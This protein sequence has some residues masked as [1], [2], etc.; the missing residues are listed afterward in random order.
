[1]S[2]FTKSP[3]LATHRQRR[4]QSKDAISSHLNSY[5]SQNIN[6]EMERIESQFVEFSK[7]IFKIV[8]KK[9]ERNTFEWNHNTIQEDKIQF[10]T[11]T[12]ITYQ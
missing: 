10:D 11:N 8:F 2:E 4:P 12:H 5:T 3:I 9:A 7:N 1:M 6:D